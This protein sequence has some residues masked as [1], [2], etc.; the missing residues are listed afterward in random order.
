MISIVSPSLAAF[1][2]LWIVGYAAE[3][4]L[5]GPEAWALG[6]IIMAVAAV[7]ARMNRIEK[8]RLE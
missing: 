6:A 1:R 3:G 4:T 7:M 5:R 8:T 2:A